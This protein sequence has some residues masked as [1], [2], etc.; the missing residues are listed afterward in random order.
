MP[1]H[2][3]GDRDQ[4]SCVE[5]GSKPR[6]WQVQI[7]SRRGP[8]RQMLRQMLSSKAEAD[9][10]Q[11]AQPSGNTYTDG[12]L[13]VLRSMRE[14]GRQRV[15]V[16]AATGPQL[17]KAVAWRGQASHGDGVASNGPLP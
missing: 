9:A 14:A 10:W 17:G 13:L 6:P 8:V 4:L 1:G 7:E 11:P 3:A 5:N 2:G 15:T 16:R 12:A